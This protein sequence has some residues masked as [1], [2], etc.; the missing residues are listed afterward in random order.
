MDYPSVYNNTSKPAVS[1]QDSWYGMCLRSRTFWV[2]RSTWLSLLGRQG[3][4]ECKW[5]DLK[6]KNSIYICFVSGK[7]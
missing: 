5:M 3:D 1:G 2:C 6:E 7:I 4:G